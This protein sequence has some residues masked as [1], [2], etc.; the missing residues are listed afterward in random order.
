MS[1][2]IFKVD[3][4]YDEIVSDLLAR[5]EENTQRKEEIEKRYK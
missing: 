4:M 5:C 1:I 2:Y 3:V